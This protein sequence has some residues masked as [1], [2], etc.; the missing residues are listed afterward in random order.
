MVKI[1]FVLFISILFFGL[2]VFWDYIFRFVVRMRDKKLGK[3]A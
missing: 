1:S 3:M 2:G